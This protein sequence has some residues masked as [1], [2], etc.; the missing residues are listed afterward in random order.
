M[1]FAFDYKKKLKASICCINL[2]HYTL[3][4]DQNQAA[5]ASNRKSRRQFLG[6]SLPTTPSS[7][8]YK[9]HA[10]NIYNY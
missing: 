2:P 10:S 1:Q 4:A 3:A 5:D 7:H 6:F 9:Y 8:A